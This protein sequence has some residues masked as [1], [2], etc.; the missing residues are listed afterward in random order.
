MLK[1]R[2]SQK[3]SQKLSPQQIQLMKLIQLPTQALEERIKEELEENPALEEGEDD[4]DEEVLP[5]NE[6]DEGDSQTIEAE[7]INVDEYLSDDE[8]PE[9]RLQANNYSPD[10]EDARVPVSGG[11]TFYEDVLD[12]L[13]M[14]MLSE[15]ERQLAEYLIGSM[16]EDGY[17]RRNLASIVD[18][19]AFSANIFTDKES[20]EKA[21]RTVQSLD[22]AGIGARSLKECLVL[23]MQRRQA[24]YYNDLAIKILSEYFDEFS[25]RHFEKIMDRLSLSNEDMKEV[26][27]IITQL[28]PKPGNSLTTQGKHISQAITPDFVIAIKE[29]ELELTLNA[30]NVPE[31]RIGGD[32][33]VML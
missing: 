25:K 13:R 26:I 33:K 4:F 2:L 9:Y 31:L 23:Q 18:D 11:Q 1:Q 24:N 22:P 6:S 32:Y 10:D 5:S 16:E 8:V 28:N 3:L 19:L 17:I 29:G 14:S 7:D 12:Q 27:S 20:L 15:L 21:L 30:R